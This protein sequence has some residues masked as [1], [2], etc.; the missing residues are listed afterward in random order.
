MWIPPS[1]TGFSCASASRVVGRM[2]WS[3]STSLVWPVGLPSS[4]GTGASIGRISLLKRPA[5][6]A[7]AARCCERSANSSACSR[8]M[9]RLPTMRS[10]LTNCD[11]GVSHFQSGGWK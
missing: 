5:S 7:A 1:C 6:R 10:T 8:V 9:P 3:C 4:P 11:G 2:P